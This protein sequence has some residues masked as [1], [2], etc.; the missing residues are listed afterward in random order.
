MATFRTRTNTALRIMVGP[1]RKNPK[2]EMRSFQFA[3]EWVQDDPEASHKTREGVLVVEDEKDAQ[4]VRDAIAAH[5][6][7]NRL[8]PWLVTEDVAA[9]T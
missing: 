5:N 2:A 4:L 6:K 8:D 9:A 1:T 3:T 7:G